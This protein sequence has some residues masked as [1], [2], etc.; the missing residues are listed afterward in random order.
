MKETESPL[1]LTELTPGEYSFRVIRDANGNGKWDVG[2]YS[3]LTQPEAVDTYSKKTKIR[4]NWT[5]DVTYKNQRDE[6]VC[7]CERTALLL[8][9]PS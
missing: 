4:A 8:R 3:T 9:K 1:V 5:I 7:R 2:E 6:V